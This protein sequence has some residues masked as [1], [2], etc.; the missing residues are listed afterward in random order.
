MTKQAQPEGQPDFFV[1]DDEP[2][3][4]LREEKLRRALWDAW[5]AGMAQ[6]PAREGMTFSVPPNPEIPFPDS[7]VAGQCE[8]GGVVTQISP[9]RDG[10]VIDAPFARWCHSCGARYD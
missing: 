5:M 2:V 4:A 7:A 1:E 9:H 8:C 10:E 6:P 3:G